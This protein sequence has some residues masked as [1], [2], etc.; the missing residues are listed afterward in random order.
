M[1]SGDPAAAIAHPLDDA[2]RLIPPCT[3]SESVLPPAAN[4]TGFSARRALP[5]SMAI[6]VI[7]S[8]MYGSAKLCGSL[9][10]FAVAPRVE[11]SNGEP[12]R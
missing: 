2:G 7:I 5:P 1:V 3:R 4:W 8:V 11:R 9:R 6:M 12:E 10:N